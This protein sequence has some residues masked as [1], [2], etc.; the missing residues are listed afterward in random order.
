MKYYHK[1]VAYWNATDPS[2]C[3]VYKISSVNTTSDYT[4]Q[5]W[6]LAVLG[7]SDPPLDILTTDPQLVILYSVLV[8]DTL[9]T[10][11]ITR[12]VAFSRSTRL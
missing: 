9:V 10:F 5:Q 2:I 12:T 3:P 8:R 1:L 11:Y 4:T 7:T 6:W